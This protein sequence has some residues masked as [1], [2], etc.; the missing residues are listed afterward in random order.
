MKPIYHHYTKWEDFQNGMYNEDKNGRRERVQK[1]IQILSNVELCYKS[2]RM[3]IS[4]WKY[5]CEQNLSNNI[6]GHRAFLG[7]AACNIYAGVHEDETRQAWGLLTDDQ[8]KQANSIA[9][10]VYREWLD[11]H[12]QNPQMSLFVGVYA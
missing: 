2:M 7:Q 5:A 1:A 12:E 9:D 6:Y 3:V 4:Q 10:R 11:E 8:R